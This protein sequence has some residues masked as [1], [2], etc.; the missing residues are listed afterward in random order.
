MTE[1]Y[2]EPQ[3]PMQE[4]DLAFFSDGRNLAKEV[5]ESGIT[6]RNLLILGIRIYQAMDEFIKAFEEQSSITGQKPDCKK[7]CS[8]CCSNAVMVL[9]HE[10]IL[11][12]EFML[13]RMTQDQINP[14]LEKFEKKDSRSSEMKSFEFMHFKSPCALLD[15]NGACMAYEVRPMAC[16][17]YL[18]KNVDSCVYE[19]N[20]S[21]DLSSYAQLFDLPLRAGR[22]MNEGVCSWLNDQGLT[23]YDWLFES[24]FLKVWKQ[25]DVLE[26]WKNDPDYFKPR[27]MDEEELKYL[28][29]FT[30]FEAF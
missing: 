20:Q 10:M 18:S 9:P 30:R 14:I 5:L 4:I 29:Q 15:E 25:P 21:K 6:K 22:M 13:Q 28:D 1:L 12:K 16:R 11:L 24:F 27:E 7:G 26:D 23:C 2:F 3:N 17:I 8:W 19:F